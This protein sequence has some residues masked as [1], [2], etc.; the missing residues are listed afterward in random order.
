MLFIEGTCKAFFTTR[1]YVFNVYGQSYTTAASTIGTALIWE[2]YLDNGL[3]SALFPGLLITVVWRPTTAMLA[4]ESNWVEVILSSLLSTE[5]V[6]VQI[7]L[8]LAHKCRFEITLSSPL[9]DDVGQWGAKIGIQ[10]IV[11][12]V[13]DP[14]VANLDPNLPI[15]A[16]AAASAA[17]LSAASV[18]LAIAD[19][20]PTAAVFTCLAI[21]PVIV[22]L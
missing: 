6:I 21:E 2:Q 3:T 12:L 10:P 19:T 7:M 11:F 5:V 9:A 1:M 18:A 4:W 20:A 14:I 16:L 17:A 8:I 15:M 13:L 22:A